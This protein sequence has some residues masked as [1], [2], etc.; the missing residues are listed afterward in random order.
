MPRAVTAAEVHHKFEFNSTSMMK[1]EDLEISRKRR[2][3]QAVWQ[4]YKK[5]RENEVS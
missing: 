2:E 4:I 1:R 5:E 3:A